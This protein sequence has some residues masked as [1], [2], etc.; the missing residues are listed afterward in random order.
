[1]KRRKKLKINEFKALL[2][3]LTETF[4]K[5]NKD[6]LDVY[7]V[8]WFGI[9]GNTDD[10]SIYQSLMQRVKPSGVYSAKYLY[11]KYRELKKNEGN[12]SYLITVS[13]FYVNCW[14]KYIDEESMQAVMS[15]QPI[16]ERAY[17]GYYYD[18]ISHEVCTFELTFSDVKGDW[19]EL[20]ASAVVDGSTFTGKGGLN[21]PFVEFQLSCQKKEEQRR[22]RIEVAYRNKLHSDASLDGAMT[23]Y[24]GFG[25]RVTV[26]EVCLLPN[27]QVK[28][29][30]L[31]AIR[32]IR[33]NHQ[34]FSVEPKPLKRHGY[35]FIGIYIVW[36][37]DSN[38]NI[39]QTKLVIREDL[40]ATLF[41]SIHDEPR[42]N[43]QACRIFV[44]NPPNNDR[45]HIKTHR[46]KHAANPEY[47]INSAI[48][49]FGSELTYGHFS[50]V[51]IK[52]ESPYGANLVFR[53]V[54]KNASD[55]HDNPEWMPK[56]IKRDEIETYV[57]EDG[58]LIAML[59][60][61]RRKQ[62]RPSQ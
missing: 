13:H 7:S 9:N 5:E 62:E 59:G 23:V 15:K 20:E 38:G 55:D 36:R 35:G 22:L 42:D 29:K 19:M 32:Y 49:Y 1:M 27:A 58:E 50:S 26:M 61:L 8:K 10:Y 39:V 14:L 33:L 56:I 17:S 40:S 52:E 45:L 37:F 18:P 51:G 54:S 31:D 16:T 6:M 2:D 57:D 12:T 4:E 3:R 11:D 21:R 30:E 53:R 34:A 24:D 41:L 25:C 47:L 44:L 46:D 60:K 48:V 28:E 43:E